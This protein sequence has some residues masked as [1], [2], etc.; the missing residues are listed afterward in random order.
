MDWC[1]AF[2]VIFQSRQIILK[3]QEILP[4]MKIMKKILTVITVRNHTICLKWRQSQNGNVKKK[5]VSVSLIGCDV[6]S[7]PERYR[8]G[9]AILK[10][11]TKHQ[12]RKW[13]QIMRTFV[14][15]TVSIVLVSIL[16]CPMVM[17]A[18]SMP[19]DLQIVQP[20]PSL[21]KE[22]SA[23]FSKWDGTSG[24]TKVFVIVEK[25]DEEKASLYIWRDGFYPEGVTLGWV[26]YEAKV[27]KEYGKYKLWLIGPRGNVVLTVKGNYLD[28]SA[29]SN[30]NYRLT[31]V[32]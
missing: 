28:Y 3:R 27:I 1:L 18:P 29:G 12:T 15:L 2:S 31:R 8:H 13:R 16:F 32:P 7:N 4:G 30:A 23:F 22:L 20:D 25:I 10:G 11:L 26:R 5:T 19:D 24:P 17:S 9:Q 14:V 6:L 21:R